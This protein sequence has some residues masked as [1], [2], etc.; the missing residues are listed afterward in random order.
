[1]YYKEESK[2]W[3]FVIERTAVEKHFESDCVLS[4]CID[5]VTSSHLGWSVLHS[6]GKWNVV[7]FFLKL[8]LRREKQWCGLSKN[9]SCMTLEFLFFCL[10]MSVCVPGWNITT[11]LWKASHSE[12]VSQLELWSCLAS[13]SWFSHPQQW[14]SPLTQVQFLSKG[15]RAYVI[16]RAVRVHRGIWN[17]RHSQI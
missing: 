11:L 12:N 10:L 15:G 1:M 16:L 2:L 5:S 14:A 4:D 7:F 8:C 9:H 6:K 3:P 13:S 17:L